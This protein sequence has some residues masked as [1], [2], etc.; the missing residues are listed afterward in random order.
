MLYFV[1]RNSAGSR[2]FCGKI[3]GMQITDHLGGQCV[4]QFLK[5][6][7]HRL[8]RV[9][10][11]LRLQ[12]ADMLADECIAA[13]TKRNG[14]F[15]MSAHGERR[16]LFSRDGN[17]QRGI[18]A[19]PTQDELPPEH[20]AHDGIIDVS[21]NRPIVDEKHVGY[22]VQSLQGLLLLNANRLIREVAACG[23][24]RKTEIPHKD[25]MQR[26]VRKHDTEVRV[27]GCDGGSDE[28]QGS[29]FKV[30]GCSRGFRTLNLKLLTFNTS[31]L[32]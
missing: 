10:R 8:K 31:F 18:S 6:L 24:D 14:I 29:G 21:D 16:M 13:Q 22:S 11:L 23:N 27:T 2:K 3:I 32:L 28:V 9:E 4:I 15:Q 17:G 20:D 12:V 1:Y 7:D 25:V 30:Q 26:G 5:I 19:C